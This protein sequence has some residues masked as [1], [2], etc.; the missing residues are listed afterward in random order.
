MIRE[1]ARLGRPESKEALR[2]AVSLPFTRP[3]EQAVAALKA[4]G[5]TDVEVSPVRPVWQF[6]FW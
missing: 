3:R 2:H 1:L 6:K 4:M 5:V